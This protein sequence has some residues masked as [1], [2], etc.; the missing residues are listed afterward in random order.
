MAEM[1]LTNRRLLAKY[2]LGF[3]SQQSAISFDL[4]TTALTTGIWNEVGEGIDR[5]QTYWQWFKEETETSGGLSS[6]LKQLIA[7]EEKNTRAVGQPLELYVSQ[8]RGQIE[9]W[10]AQ[11][12]LFEKPKLRDVKEMML[13]LGMRQ[14]QGRWVKG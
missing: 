2:N 5:L 12:W 14:Q 9:M 3:S 1:F 7:Q 4:L 11:G 10:V 6:L 13:D 8:I